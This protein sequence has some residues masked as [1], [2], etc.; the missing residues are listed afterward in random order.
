MKLN[1]VCKCATED[2]QPS[3]ST[4]GEKPNTPFQ[5]PIFSPLL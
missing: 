2:E 3:A 5:P 1:T 4:V